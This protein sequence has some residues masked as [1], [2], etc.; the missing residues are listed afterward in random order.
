[1]LLLYR[2]KEYWQKAKN[3][4]YNIYKWRSILCNDYDWDYYYTYNALYFKICKQCEWFEN[5]IEYQT[6]NNIDINPY[7]RDMQSIR[8][9]RIAKKLLEI[10]YLDESDINADNLPKFNVRQ[11]E[12]PQWVKNN[13]K[14]D[15]NYINNK[16]VLEGIYMYRC[17]KL[18]FKILLEES[19]KW[20]D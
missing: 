7:C 1:M 15:L 5:L 12:L 4:T 6:I 16:Y 13:L 17:K 2:L 18:L 8:Y 14:T 19:N 20:W 11:K 10:T 9:M 3:F